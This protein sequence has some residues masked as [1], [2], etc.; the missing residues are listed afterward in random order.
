MRRADRATLDHR[1]PGR[2]TRSSLRAGR[3]ISA[4]VTATPSPSWSAITTP[5]RRPASST[6]GDPLSPS[7]T[8]GVKMTHVAA[9]GGPVGGV[10]DDEGHLAVDVDV[11]GAVGAEQLAVVGDRRCRV[12]GA[13]RVGTSALTIARSVR[14][15]MVTTRAGSPS[16]VSSRSSPSTVCPAVST[17]SSPTTMPTPWKRFGCWQRC[18]STATIVG[19][20]T[21]LPQRR[22]HTRDGQQDRRGGRQAL[23]VS[24]SARRRSCTLTQTVG[25]RRGRRAGRRRTR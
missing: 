15:S 25:R 21:S 16:T 1:T 9:I 3:L 24:V 18:V 13:A 2:P 14:R 20:W 12:G 8:P 7:T 10:L 19:G 17:R 23:C 6:M 5:T 22:R 4:A 11:A